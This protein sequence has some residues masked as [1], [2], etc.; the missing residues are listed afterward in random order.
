M[1]GRILNFSEFFGKYS[2]DLMTKHTI[3]IKLD[4]IA[5]LLVELK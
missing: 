2:K 3:K 1:P 4:Q 5:Q